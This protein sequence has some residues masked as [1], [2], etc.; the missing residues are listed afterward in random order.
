MT[1]IRVRFAPSPTGPLHIGGLRTALYN[2]LFAK[3]NNGSMILRIEDTDQTRLVPGA[4]E[5]IKKSLHWIGIEPDESPENPGEFGPYRQSERMAIYSKYAWELVENG[6]A[7]LA[8]DTPDELSEMRERLK[9]QGADYQNY[10]HSS[11]SLMKN[12]L[13]LPM[14]EIEN[15][16]KTESFVIRIKVDPEQIISFEDHIRGKIQVNSSQL[17]DKVI[18]KSDGMPTYHLA[19]VVDDYLMKISHVIRGE[20]WLPSTPL[21]ILLYNRL[22]W[23]KN[24]PQM[25]HLPLLLKPSGKGKLSKRDADKDGFPIFP[26]DWKDPQTNELSIGYK[27]QGYQPDAFLNFLTFLGWNPGTEQEIY[28]LEELT[29][30]FDLTKVNKSGAKFD[31]DKA[32]WFNQKYLKQVSDIEL[33]KEIVQN[34][35][36]N[37]QKIALGKAI[38]IAGLMKGRVDFAKDLWQNN[39]Y[40]Y[41]SPEKY[42]EKVSRKKWG[43]EAKLIAREFAITLENSD[44]FDEDIAKNL[45]ESTLEKNNI[46]LGKVFQ[47]IRL[48]ITGVGGG[49]DLMQVMSIIGK[50][51]TVKRLKTAIKTL[52]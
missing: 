50:E 38:K 3:R 7:Y 34:I 19:N 17:D 2:Y 48:A 29:K 15:L 10:G 8:F 39:C 22:G 31:V 28:S 4:E 35:N 46:S 43:P 47:A 23:G 14:K 25:A 36:S 6:H 27:G 16:K 30:V 11:R 44:E 32:I 42:D 13:S 41:R 24:I 52:P 33:A 49:P 20:E 1:E 45:L 9:N 18:L 40:L 26:L 51:E 12:S 21:H 37:D 5:Y